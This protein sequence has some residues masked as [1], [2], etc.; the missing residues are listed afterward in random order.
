MEGTRG[1]GC[2]IKEKGDT[3][4]EDWCG[5]GKS[6]RK[7]SIS[8]KIEMLEKAWRDAKKMGTIPFFDI[9]FVSKEL[10][11]M[12]RHWCLV[13]GPVFQLLKDRLTDEEKELVKP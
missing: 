6:T 1:S 13:P 8:I 12:P 10:P 2:G 11:G 9:D 3:K 7:K 4:D 5:E